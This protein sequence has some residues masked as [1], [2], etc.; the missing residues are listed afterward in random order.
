MLLRAGC[1]AW[2]SRLIFTKFLLCKCCWQLAITMTTLSISRR[3]PLWMAG[4]LMRVNEETLLHNRSYTNTDSDLQS[5]VLCATN[6][7]TFF[8]ACQ[9]KHWE[10]SFFEELMPWNF[11]QQY[12]KT[13]TSCTNHWKYC[14]LVLQVQHS[15]AVKEDFYAEKANLLCIKIKKIIWE[16]SVKSYKAQCTFSEHYSSFRVAMSLEKTAPATSRLY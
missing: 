4:V 16:F 6:K 5:L 12:A 13:I 11:W 7:C 14:K 3:L 10:F 1:T 9:C 15:V 2:N 8:S